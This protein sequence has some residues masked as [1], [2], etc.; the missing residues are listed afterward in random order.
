MTTF[1]PLRVAH[2][3]HK[4]PELREESGQK[5]DIVCKHSGKPFCRVDAQTSCPENPD[6]EPPEKKPCIIRRYWKLVQIWPPSIRTCH[7]L[8]SP[9]GHAESLHLRR[10]RLYSRSIGLV[11]HQCRFRELLEDPVA[12]LAGGVAYGR[13]TDIMYPYKNDL[14]ISDEEVSLLATPGAP[15]PVKF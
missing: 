15:T 1:S 7:Q 3:H 4:H 2:E 6:Y 10:T 5:Q 11:V 9:R 8:Q 13:F 14:L 12:G